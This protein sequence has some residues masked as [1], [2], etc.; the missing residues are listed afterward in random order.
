MNDTLEIKKR[1]PIGEYQGAQGA[2]VDGPVIGR[3]P[4]GRTH[5][6]RTKPCDYLAPDVWFLEYFMTYRVGIDHNGSSL[7]H[8]TGDVT[9]AA[10]NAP[11]QSN[12]GNRPRLFRAL[13]RGKP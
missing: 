8:Q 10:A 3:I 5:D 1:A 11:D 6:S 2:P 9:L 13:Q 4:R 12:H 7:A